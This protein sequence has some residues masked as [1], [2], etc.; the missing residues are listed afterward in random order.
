MNVM[1]ARCC[2]IDAHKTFVIACLS[3]KEEGVSRKEVRRFATMS[4]DLVTLRSWLLET[5]C[6]HVSMEST[7]VYWRTVYAHLHG[8]FEIVVANAQHMKAV[9]GRKVRPEVA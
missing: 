6:T 2:G 4:R 8:F 1:Y 9:P 7:G 5:G 3:I